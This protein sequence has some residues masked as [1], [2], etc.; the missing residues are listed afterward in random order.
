MLPNAPESVPTHPGRSERVQTRLGTYE[1]FEKLRENFA[2]VACVA[3]LFEV[4]ETVHLRNHR[5]VTT[6]MLSTTTSKL[7]STFAGEA[8]C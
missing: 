4:V 8:G 5:G 3:S 7:Q 6:S 2:K 1:N